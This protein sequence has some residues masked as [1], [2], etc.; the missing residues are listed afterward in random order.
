MNS[1]RSSLNAAKHILIP[2]GN[3]LVPV[4]T[5][6]Q[7]QTTVT[8]SAF[9]APVLVRPALSASLPLTSITTHR[10]RASF[11][12]RP[13]RACA[14][15]SNPPPAADT[16]A[17]A[18]TSS[19]P[20]SPKLEPPP[21]TFYQ[22]ISQAFSATT[23]ALDAGHTLLEIEFPPLP[24]SQLESA[25]VSA[26]DVADANL[27]LVI[28]FADRWADS[29]RVTLA[30]PDRIERDR[31]EEA[32]EATLAERP[33]IRIACLRD[34]RPGIFIE[35]LWTTPE[36]EVAIQPDDDIIIVLGASCQELPDVEA[37][38]T[39][40]EGRPVI[41][42]NLKLDTSRGDLGLPAFPR[43]AMHDRF[44]SRALPVYYLRT[45]TYSRS[46]PRPP[47]IVNYSG[48]LFRVFPGDYQVLLD[49][50][51][52]NYR[53]LT[54]LARRPPLGEVRDIL[55]DGMNLD[56]E[57][58]QNGFMYKGYK[59]RTWWEEERPDAASDLWRS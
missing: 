53:R 29:R 59:S 16:G 54:T 37:L 30:F 45:R 40:A 1:S 35:R 28:D 2:S 10:R 8:M 19:S 17:D 22:A 46:L 39:A 27:R 5:R 4:E 36:V 25:A 20:A 23:A 43:K 38:V 15:P 24:A 57:N 33:H 41:L 58:G 32:A 9:L 44:L 12:S 11:A 6:M 34:S 42:F 21:N 7:F 55:T 49:T 3:L 56:D 31:A 52:G 14:Q 50:S 26:T 18:G 51:A 47:Y 48:A 13:T